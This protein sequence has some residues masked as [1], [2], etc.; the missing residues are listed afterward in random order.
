MSEEKGVFIRQVPMKVKGDD[1]YAVWHR[2]PLPLQAP[3]AR[4]FGFAQETVLLR[5]G[6]IRR[7]GAMPLLCDIYLDRN[8]PVTLRDGITIFTDVFRPVH[9]GNYPAIVSWSPYGKEVGS[10]SVDDFPERSGV[11]LGR[12]SELNKFEGIDPAFWVNRG[13]VVLQPDSRGAYKSE[14]NLVYWGTQLGE[15]GYD[16]VEWAADQNWSNGK[17]GMAGN[18]FLAVSQ[19]FIAAQ[20]PPHLAAI[21]PWEGLSDAMRNTFLRGGIPTLTFP[22][23]INQ[24][25]AG[26]NLL[27][28]PVRMA[29]TEQ[30]DT[31]YWKDKAAQ[32]GDIKVPAYIVAS[33]DNMAH[34]QGTFDAYTDIGSNQKWLRVHNTMEWPDFYE[35]RYVEELA[36]FFDHY[37]KGLANT[38][39]QTPQVRISVIDPGGEDE[40]E[41][42]VDSWP[43]SGYQH[44][45]LFL[46]ADGTMNTEPAAD[47]ASLQYAVDDGHPTVFRMKVDYAAEIIGQLKLKLWVE[48]RGSDDMDL[49]VVVEKLSATGQITLHPLGTGEIK[50]FQAVGL[51][52]TS[53][54]R[55]DEHR[56]T[57][58]YPVLL[59]QDD[60]RLSAGEI[61]PLEISLSPLGL[62]LHKGEIL[63]VMV[64]PYKPIPMSLP[65][66]S[67]RI[68]VPVGCFTYPPG[69]SVESKT[70]GGDASTSPDWV[71]QQEVPE[72]T[73]NSGLHVFHIGGDY[74]SHL[75]VPIKA[76]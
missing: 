55:L 26:E 31:L 66:G 4:Y 13:Y 3:R 1:K 62:R 42:V 70:L 33:Y 18:S 43:P 49:V 22:E 40:V 9:S 45:A 23:L 73:R 24:S 67:A 41:R 61:V 20:Q 60:Q 15:D 48:A 39:L 76:I 5:K 47:P 65:L 16:F 25:L 19:W 6:E 34:T 10:E 21:A 36:G 38:W 11:A 71:A 63:Q 57:P 17:I 14:G 53:R 35:P 72:T 69:E 51:Q 28:D 56:S 64:A 59:M 46:R 58:A 30:N 44:R 37:L 8:V 29:V 54:R 27:E 75:L 2:R 12:L 68:S 74:D 52:R 32:V 7:D 50:P